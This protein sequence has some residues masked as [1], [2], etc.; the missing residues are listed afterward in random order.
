MIFYT[1]HDGNQWSRQSDK[2]ITW[3]V[4]SDINASRNSMITTKSYFYLTM[5]V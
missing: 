1:K 5:A 4:I 2:K 3:N